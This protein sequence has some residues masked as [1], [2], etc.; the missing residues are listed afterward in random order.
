MLLMTV[1]WNVNLASNTFQVCI[2]MCADPM[3]TGREEEFTANE[4]EDAIPALNDILQTSFASV[5]MTFLICTDFAILIH[6]HT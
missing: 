5:C 6:P 3:E 2:F 1:L 4:C